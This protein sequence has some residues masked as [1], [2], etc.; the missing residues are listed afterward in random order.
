M[1]RFRGDIEEGDEAEERE[2][3]EGVDLRMKKRLEE[4]EKF[5]EENFMRLNETKQEKYWKKQMMKNRFR[6]TMNDELNE[7]GLIR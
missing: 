2:L 3:F 5:E 6:N 4:K 1:R 7:I